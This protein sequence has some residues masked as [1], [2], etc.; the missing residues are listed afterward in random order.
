LPSSLISLEIPSRGVNN[1]DNP[2]SNFPNPVNKNRGVFDCVQEAILVGAEHGTDLVADHGLSRAVDSRQTDTIPE[3]DL[4]EGTLAVT[5]YLEQ[6]LRDSSAQLSD[7]GPA[8]SAVD[9][10]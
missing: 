8:E 3:G 1:L 6:S 5:T 7:P 2:G 10:E 9:P 4:V